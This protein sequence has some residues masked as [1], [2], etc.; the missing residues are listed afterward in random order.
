MKAFTVLMKGVGEVKILVSY[1]KHDNFK[2]YVTNRLDWREKKIAEM[3]SRRWD[4]EVWH[5]EGRGDYGIEECLLRSD[6][7][8]SRLALSSLAANLLEIAS[9]RSPLYAM[10]KTRART[11]EAK[12]RCL[13]LVS[14]LISYVSRAKDGLMREAAGSVV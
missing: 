4:I 1:N 9:L 12:R 13:E 8:V 2:F 5:R 6:E 7:A 14:Q 11:P 3:Y 10:L